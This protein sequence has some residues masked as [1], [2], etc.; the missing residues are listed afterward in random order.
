MMETAKD[1]HI[2]ITPDGPRGPRH[3]LKPGI[4]FLASHTGRKIVPTAFICKRYWAIK[5]NWTDMMIPK[6]FTKI[7]ALGGKPLEVPPDLSKEQMAE[8]LGKLKALMED[9][10]EKAK[11]LANGESAEIVL[12][13]E[14]TNSKRA[15]A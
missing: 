9:C 2:T 1:H 3:E 15:A 6:P 7:I 4:V 11:R 10:E 13:E 8:Y 5:G 14:V 12:A